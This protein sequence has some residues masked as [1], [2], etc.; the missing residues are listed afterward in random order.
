[1]ARC[2]AAGEIRGNVLLTACDFGMHALGDLR[3]VCPWL[4]FCVC[5]C[6]MHACERLCMMAMM[7]VCVYLRAVCGEMDWDLHRGCVLQKMVGSQA[8]RSVRRGICATVR[9]AKMEALNGVMAE[10]AQFM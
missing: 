9:R 2:T 6:F 5:L 4:V 7:C 1:V 8:R 3:P 10:A